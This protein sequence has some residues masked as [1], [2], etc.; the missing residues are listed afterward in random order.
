MSD[1]QD[2]PDVACRDVVELV[3]DYLEGALDPVTAAAVRRHLSDC[4]GCDDYLAQMRAT[5]SATG[6]VPLESLSE[7]AKADLVAAFRDQLP[8][9]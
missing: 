9:R 4:P 1:H 2:A 8:G 7:R 5:I 6:Q 3:T